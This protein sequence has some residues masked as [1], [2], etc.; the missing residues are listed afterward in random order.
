VKEILVLS[1]STKRL[2]TCFSVL[3]GKAQVDEALTCYGYFCLLWWVLLC[4]I[5]VMDFSLGF[6]TSAGLWK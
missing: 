4:G 2:Y 5:T 1:T 3:I 6:V